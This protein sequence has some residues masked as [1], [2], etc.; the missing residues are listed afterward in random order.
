NRVNGNNGQVN[1]NY[2][3]EVLELYTMG[4]NGGYKQADVYDCSRCLSGHTLRGFNVYAYDPALHLPGNKLVLGKTIVSN[5]ELEL[6]DLID[7]VI[8]PWPATAEFLVTKIWNYFVSDES[9]PALITEL[10]TRFRS[11]GFSI[12]A[13][14]DTI[15]RSTIFY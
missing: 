8:L 12:L 14:M 5:G 6:Y 1:E 15:L 2:G 11:S 7:N 13:V 9:Y 4:V 10:A 3:R